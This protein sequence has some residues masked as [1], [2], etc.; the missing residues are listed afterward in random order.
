MKPT[1]SRTS[2]IIPAALADAML[3]RMY[4]PSSEWTAPDLDLSALPSDCAYFQVPPSLASRMFAAYYGAV[5]S[6][7]SS[8]LPDEPEAQQNVP[9]AEPTTPEDAKLI[10]RLTSAY[11][12]IG[13]ARRR[14]IP[15]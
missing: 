4:N 11:E 15:T 7:P 13:A 12:P 5:P 14:S 3:R 6:Q 8:D 2:V 1:P 10:K 9:P